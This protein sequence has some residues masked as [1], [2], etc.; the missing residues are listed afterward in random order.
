[1][2]NWFLIEMVHVMEKAIT[3]YVICLIIKNIIN[4][5]YAECLLLFITCFSVFK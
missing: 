5:F 3:Q 1:M 2:N 4:C